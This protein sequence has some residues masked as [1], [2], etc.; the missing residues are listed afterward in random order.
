MEGYLH[1]QFTLHRQYHFNLT[2]LQRVIRARLLNP[3]VTVIYD[4]QRKNA[5]VRIRG[6]GKIAVFPLNMVNTEA[7]RFTSRW[8]ER[9]RLVVCSHA[10]YNHYFGRGMAKGQV[11][12]EKGILVSA[13]EDCR[14][15]VIERRK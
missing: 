6:E 12:L 14:R 3:S 10:F 13:L 2:D 9:R 4:R 7:S 8:D 11:K 5:E 15:A 1:T